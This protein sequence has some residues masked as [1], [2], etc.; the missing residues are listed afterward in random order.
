MTRAGGQADY[1]QK[2]IPVSLLEVH[3]SRICC[4]CG[5]IEPDSNARNTW[6]MVLALALV[7][8]AAV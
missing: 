8:A 6:N 2:E 1:L 4:G 5:V 7:Y 3:K